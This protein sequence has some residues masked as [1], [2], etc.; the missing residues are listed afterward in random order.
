MSRVPFFQP[1]ANCW[2]TAPARR[3]G[4]LIDGAAY[5]RALRESLLKARR[6]IFIIGWDF[7]A[8]IVL[9]PIAA[10]G[11]S[12][13]ALL[14]ELARARPQ[15][16]IRV[17]IWSFSTFYGPSRTPTLATRPPWR[18]DAPNIAFHYDSVYPL[19]ACHHEKIVCIDDWVAFVGGIDLTAER[20]DTPAHDP[21]EPHR[22]EHDGRPFAPV[23]DLQ[24]VFDGAAAA[25]GELVRERWVIATGNRPAGPAPRP[26]PWPAVTPA[27]MSDVDIAIARTRSPLGGRPAIQEAK[28]LNIDVL[29]AARRSLYIET[30]YLT[31]QTVGDVLAERLAERDGPE[32]VIVVTKESKG[33]VEQFAMGSNRDRLLRRLQAAD[34]W[35]RLR[36]FYP[37]VPQPDGSD[38]PVGIHSKLIVA[39]DRIV[40]NGSSNLNNRSLGLDTECDIAIDAGDDRQRRHAIRRLRNRLLAEHMG[41]QPE[42]VDAAEAERGSVRAAIDALNTGRRRLCPLEVDPEAGTSEPIPGTAILD[43]DEPLDLTYFR[44]V[45]PG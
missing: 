20:W 34:R 10:P 30:Q 43:P 3:V 35:D 27:F 14:T 31:A 9:D 24:F 17:L 40:R 8:N 18:I 11:Q 5:F 4:V 2:R 32:V 45:L 25:I 16:E 41:V 7:D 22:F 29:R 26:D 42:A 13:G 21:L 33:W 37:V 38:C 28:A 44:Q 6:S 23:H 15:L 19:G 12:L 36:V 1:G 39:D